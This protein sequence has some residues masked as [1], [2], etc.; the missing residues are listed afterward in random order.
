MP[1]AH[2]GLYDF[3]LCGGTGRIA[4]ERFMSAKEWQCEKA[5]EGFTAFR[6]AWESHHVLK[7]PK[8][9][10]GMSW[11]ATLLTKNSDYWECFAVQVCQILLVAVLLVH[12]MV[13]TTLESLLSLN[14]WSYT[15]ECINICIYHC[16]HP[17]YNYIVITASGVRDAINFLEPF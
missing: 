9:L 6:G 1:N 14:C 16:A 2:Q 11:V 17:L 13:W 10:Y 5:Q 4:A 8:E 12:C 15:M 3:Y 7:S